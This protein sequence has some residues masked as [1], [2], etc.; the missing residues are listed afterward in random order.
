MARLVETHLMDTRA[1][2][3]I[4]V[5]SQDVN[6]SYRPLFAKPG[7]RYRGI[8]MTAGPNVDIVMPDPYELPLSSRSVDLV[9]SG[10]RIFQRRRRT[11]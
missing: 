6:G 1:P 10:N 3:V 9:I 7:W 11:T 5:G 2:D 4:D 8:D